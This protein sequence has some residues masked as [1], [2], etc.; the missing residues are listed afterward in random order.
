MSHH[1]R[2]LRWLTLVI[3]AATLATAAHAA[4]RN[5]LQFIEVAFN[6]PHSPFHKPP[7]A[8]HSRDALPKY[9][10]GVD[11]RGDSHLHPCESCSG[12]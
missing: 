12:P 9:K 11:R 3:A 4:P 8:L 6:A 5:I 7:N 1:S 10:P 2:L